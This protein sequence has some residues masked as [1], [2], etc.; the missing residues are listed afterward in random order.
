MDSTNP[1]RQEKKI[2]DSYKLLELMQGKQN[3]RLFAGLNYYYVARRL[4]EA[5]HS[6]IEFMAEIILNY[7]K[8]LEV[9]FGG[10]RESIRQELQK[11]NISKEDIEQVF[12]PVILLRNEFDVGHALVTQI[13]QVD[14]YPLNIFVTHLERDFEDLI[15]KLIDGIRGRTY[16]MIPHD[17]GALDKVKQAKLDGILDSILKRSQNHPRRFTNAK[18][19]IEKHEE[20]ISKP[21]PTKTEKR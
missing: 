2:Y 3:R 16:E 19:I 8:C 21:P 11:L 20:R 9:M 17:A 5:G 15:K 13:N 7:S 14:I 10:T 4:Y 12:I 1:E 6:A 18:N